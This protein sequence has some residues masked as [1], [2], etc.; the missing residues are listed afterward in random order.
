MKLASY[1]VENLFQRAR[2]MNLQTWNEG[3]EAL[4]LHAEMN[5]IINKQTYSAADKKRILEIMKK[6]GISNKDDGKLVILRQNRGHLVKR[7]KGKVEV[8]AEGRASWIGWLDLVYEEVDETATRNTA[9]VIRDVDAHVIGIVEAESRPGL[10]HFSRNVVPA[11][12]GTAYEHIMLVDGNDER[13]IDVAI[14][15]RAGFEIASIHSHVDDSSGGKLIFSRDCPEYEIATPKGNRLLVLVNHFK[16]KG[17]GKQSD[18]NEKRRLQ[19][20]RVKEIYDQRRRDGAK[21]IAVIGDFNDTPDSA[22]LA[23]LLTSTSLKD[24]TTHPSFVSDGRPGTFG[25]GAKSSKIDYIL[26]SP[27]LL[28]LVKSGGIFRMGVWGGKNG[29]LFPHFPEITKASEA[30][31]DHAAVWAEIDV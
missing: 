6:L 9:R 3:R 22:P 31:S 29:T 4:Q 24:I 17:F 20:A 19:A 10:L 26:L 14:M 21:L 16:S 7:S 5:Q 27:E 30:A 25:S 15:A 2:A 28:Q 11:V 23:P 12:G 18:S 8:V 1:N 13:G